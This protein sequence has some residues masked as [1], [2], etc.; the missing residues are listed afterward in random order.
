MRVLTLVATAWAFSMPV[1]PA[2]AQDALDADTKTQSDA[3]KSSE[4]TITSNDKEATDAGSV[5]DQPET[6]DVAEKALPN[7]SPSPDSGVVPQDNSSPRVAGASPES[8]DD[9]QKAQSAGSEAGVT[10]GNKEAPEING[11]ASNRLAYSHTGPFS[12]RDTPSLLELLEA[13]MQLR[14]NLGSKQNFM[15]ADA[16]LFYQGGWL[17]RTGGTDRLTLNAGH[18]IPALHPYFVPS[19]IYLSLS[20]RPWLNFLVGKKRIIWGSGLTFNPTNLLSPAKDPTDP[21]L[22]RAGNWVARV[23]LPFEKVTFT[24]LFAP[25]A[26]YTE[27]GIPY[28][29]LRYP[30]Y[31]SSNSTEVRDNATHYLAAGRF[32]ALLG[33]A[34][35]N[36][37]YFFSN[38]YQDNF[39]NKSRFGVSFARYFFTDYEFHLEALL[40]RGSARD[41]AC[42]PGAAG[43]SDN[44]TFAATKLE[45]KTFYPRVLVGTRRQFADESMLTL[46]YYYQGDG[47][48]DREFARAV[49]L[50]STNA[51][52]AATGAQSNALPQ[53]FSFDPMRRHYLFA[54]YSKPRIFDDWTAGAMLLAGLR[55]LSGLFVPSVSWST[56]EW[57]TLT[58]YG[59]VPIH[60][61]G[62]GEVTANNRKVSEY[63]LMPFDYRVLF[64]AR[65]YY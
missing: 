54:S 27:A 47:Y 19:E 8:L 41:F 39:R 29:M 7:A 20:A 49:P 33:D 57:L 59:Y 12:T 56:K 4:T 16:S 65:V 26:L 25:Q 44:P 55:D 40:T 6:P 45:S 43:C 64:E 50:M 35:L 34:D 52:S 3:S 17:F 38:H 28:A 24:A 51:V 22:Q 63:S 21:N 61:L 5:S 18:D 15:Y 58:V 62:V 9:F 36:L 37:M 30:S 11:Y 60:G 48:T 46:E 42:E 13:N 1:F 31:Q 2:Y 23:E 32:Y 14:V 10:P 53:S